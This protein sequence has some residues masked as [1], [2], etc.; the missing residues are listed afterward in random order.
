MSESCFSPE[1][2]YHAFAADLS[3]ECTAL[4]H[5]PVALP[6]F[7]VTQ[8][9]GAFLFIVLL[10]APFYVMVL[11]GKPVGS[12]LKTL[13]VANVFT[14]PVVYFGFPYLFSTFGWSEQSYILS[15]EIFMVAYESMVV[16]GRGDVTWRRSIVWILAA[17]LCSWWFGGFLGL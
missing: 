5:A 11:R 15:A 12:R 10:E 2:L 6:S 16:V 14:H 13:L 1:V 17:N 7:S 8:Y 9:L 4:L 3:K